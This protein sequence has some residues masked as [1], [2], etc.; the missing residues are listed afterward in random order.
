MIDINDVFIVLTPFQKREMEYMFPEKIKSKSSLI[1]KSK[2][3]RGFNKNTNVITLNFENFSIFKILKNPIKQITQTRKHFTN[4]NKIIHDLEFK[5][6][7]KNGFHLIIGSDKDHFTQ[8]FINKH[9]KKKTKI[10]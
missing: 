5:Y 2:I 1:I 6:L 9:I 3:V 4:L 7:F 8:L 10:N